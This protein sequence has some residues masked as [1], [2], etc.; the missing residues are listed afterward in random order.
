MFAQMEFDLLAEQLHIRIIARTGE[1]AT[2]P[3]D[4]QIAEQLWPAF[5]FQMQRDGGPG[6]FFAP[7][8]VTA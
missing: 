5:K 4:Q 7:F 6:P 3:D 8:P 1:P 2:P